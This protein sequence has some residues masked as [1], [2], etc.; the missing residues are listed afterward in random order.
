MACAPDLASPA[1]TTDCRNGLAGASSARH[2]T[3]QVEPHTKPRPCHT[4]ASQQERPRVARHDHP[5]PPGSPDPS[6]APVCLEAPVSTLS[7]VSRFTYLK[8]MELHCDSYN[9]RS[10]NNS[11]DPHYFC[12]VIVCPQLCTPR[13]GKLMV[14][15]SVMLGSLAQL[16]EELLS[17]LETHFFCLWG[18]WNFGVS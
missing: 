8:L 16:T 7:P 6:L 12:A 11:I 18:F 4:A 9:F 5:G 15:S 10:Q 2:W 1:E 3:T 13:R 17:S 14:F